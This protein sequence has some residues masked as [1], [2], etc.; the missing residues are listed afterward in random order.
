MPDRTRL[1]WSDLPHGDAISALL[2]ELHTLTEGEARDMTA[3]QWGAWHSAMDAARGAARGTQRGAP[4]DATM[5]ATL[6]AVR[7]GAQR[8]AAWGAAWVAKW[9]AAWDTALALV[10][11]DL[12]GQYGLTREH[13]DTL[14]GPARA[15]P[16][17][18]TIIDRALPTKEN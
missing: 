7:A 17:L 9:E 13:L 3:A 6:G 4:W 5:D 16:R 14:T 15:V 1:L 8:G 12:V 2:D 18:A 11:A 10:V